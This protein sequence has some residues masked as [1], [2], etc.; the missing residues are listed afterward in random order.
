MV[1]SIVGMI[2]IDAIYINNGGGKVLLDYLI[3]ELEKTDTKIFY[4][5]DSR[6][7]DRHQAIK[8][9][10]QIYYLEAGI[11]RRYSFY[12]NRTAQFSKVFCFG[13]LP[14][15]IKLT[16][17]VYTYFHN[18]MYLDVP[19]EF[20]TLD[21]IKFQIKIMVLSHFKVNTS[22]WFVQSSLIKLKLQKKFNIRPDQVKVL[23]FYEQFG[24]LKEDIIREKFTYI[25]VSNGTPHKNHERLID[26][27]CQF[28]NRN[29]KGKLILTLA[30][31]YSYLLNLISEKVREGYPIENIGY[32][33]RDTLHEQYL[34]SE[35]LI[36]PSL[37]ES[38]GLGL[39]EA[40]E[41]GCKVIGADLPYTYEICKPSVI[42]DPIITNSIINAFE[43]TL[44]EEIRETIPEIKNNVQE[45]I[46]IVT[47][48]ENI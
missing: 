6:V 32:V 16:S 47:S 46:N 28:Y 40:I 20:S 8:S 36:F 18:P 42:F 24:S 43:K 45:L 2:L 41:C 30:G 34:K 26:A 29:Q 15:N 11:S 37:T 19:K 23:P 13:N 7:R 31:D 5:L 48:A 33:D 22:F 27:F 35:F 3:Y 4:L 17:I 14:P 21:R 9:E 25:Y 1:N 44:N 12:K 39:I 10:N 38:F